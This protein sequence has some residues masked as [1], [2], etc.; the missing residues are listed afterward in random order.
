V[1]ALDEDL[2]RI[3]LY[4]RFRGDLCL[5]CLRVHRRIPAL[6]RPIH[7]DDSC[8]YKPRVANEIGAQFLE[9]AVGVPADIN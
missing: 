6:L 3:Y 4:A 8:R 5:R 9:Y 1:I 2:R 7:H